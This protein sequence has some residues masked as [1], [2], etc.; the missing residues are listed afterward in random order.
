MILRGLLIGLF[1]AAVAVVPR[2]LWH[3]F[4]SVHWSHPAYL[5]GVALVVA[6]LAWF[7]MDRKKSGLRPGYF[8]LADLLAQIHSNP[9]P[10]ASARWG[11]RG[12]ISFLLSLFGANAGIEGA[13]IEF[14]HGAAVKSRTHSSHWFEQLRRTDAASA[15]AGGVA[16]AF[17]A[18]FA[19][20]LLPIE[21]GLGGRTLSAV[22]SS[23][24]AVLV[25]HYSVQ[26]LGL[27]I[28]DLSAY[29]QSNGEAGWLSWSSL[30]GILSAAVVG[31][32]VGRVIVEFVRYTRRSFDDFLGERA[33]P[34]LA[35]GAIVL[36]LIML[37][38]EP[39]HAPPFDLIHRVFGG[40]GSET[41]PAEL[42]LLFLA[43]FLTF[44]VI[45]GVFGTAGVFW[46]VFLLGC[47][48][49]GILSLWTG[50]V[51]ALTVLCGAAALWGAVLGTP[52]AGGLLA[53]EA[54]GDVAVLLPCLAAALVA[55]E[56]V[57]LTKGRSLLERD[58]EMQGIVLED[59][60][61]VTVLDSVY[62]RE[63]MV[64]DHAQVHEHDAVA[65]IYERLLASKYPF[66]PVVNAGGA[67]TGLLTADMVEEAWEAQESSGAPL[68]K[69][70]EAKDLLYRSGQK[71]QP[72]HV[73][74]RLTV[75]VGLFGN[76]PVIPVVGD[77]RR[78]VGLLF[79][80][81]VRIAYDREVARRAL[82]FRHDGRIR[83]IASE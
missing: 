26:Y 76:T 31:G 8:G 33:W 53:Y 72:I 67:Y 4:E 46:P 38:Y 77:D 82:F 68:T 78:V 59:G 71:T 54:T 10:E 28:F 9:A 60:R 73:D 6:L 79:N 21:L 49:G 44:A 16:A 80:Y 43:L 30:G 61:S 40:A 13:A 74:D 66:L 29:V 20:V 34:R 11:V 5:A 64:T 36:A 62:V 1:A 65:D 70:L 45:A 47:V 63:A 42:G 2:I 15:V 81:N 35:V 55:R 22:L 14:S 23:V 39:A 50:S 25:V 27:P 12:V 48:L 56:I 83:G 75:T 69:L 3:R 37:A 58:L 32:L 51:P 41:A 7:F 17:G 19:A 18:P 52:L 24:A 57:R